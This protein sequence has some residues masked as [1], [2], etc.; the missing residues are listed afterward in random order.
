MSGGHRRCVS[1]GH[2]RLF[3]KFSG[4]VGN[5]ICDV[6]ENVFPGKHSLL[7]KLFFYREVYHTKRMQRVFCVKWSPDSEFIL[8]GSDEMN[9]R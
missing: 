4:P 7:V 2:P 9:V 8:S 6:E 1:G 3:K 5:I